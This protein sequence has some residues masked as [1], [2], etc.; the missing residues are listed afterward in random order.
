MIPLNYY[1]MNILQKSI[2][3]LKKGICK[4]LLSLL[5]NYILD[6]K[7]KVSISLENKNKSYTD[8]KTFKQ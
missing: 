4:S 1:L 5:N 6:N 3:S 7:I 2:I 8:P